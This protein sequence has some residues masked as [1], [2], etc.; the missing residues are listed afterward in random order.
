MVMV[1]STNLLSTNQG[2]AQLLMDF[3][4]I[5]ISFVDIKDL[6]TEI[7]VVITN[8]NEVFADFKRFCRPEPNYVYEV[9]QQ[10]NRLKSSKITTL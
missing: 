6:F 4:I 1:I 10:S 5:L 3:S 2:R 9:S 8:Q 7:F